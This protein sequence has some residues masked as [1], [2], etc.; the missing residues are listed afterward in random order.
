VNDESL[1]PSFGDIQALPSSS[2]QVWLQQAGYMENRM[3]LALSVSAVHAIRPTIKPTTN[4]SKQAYRCFGSLSHNG[5][6][7]CKS[8]VHQ[9]TQEMPPETPRIPSQTL[10]LA[11]P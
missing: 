1:R 5:G 3:C 2:C 11:V 7:Y 9:H 8:Q 6:I 10:H 4:T